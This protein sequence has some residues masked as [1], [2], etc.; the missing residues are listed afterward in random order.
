MAAE[1]E[2]MEMVVRLVGENERYLHS[3][4]EA[5]E[6]TESAAKH[7]EAAT[8]HVKHFSEQVEGFGRSAANALA[9]L[10]LATSAEQA[11]E[12][13][14]SLE[15]TTLRLEAAIEGNGR[16]A[17]RAM[18]QYNEFAAAMARTTLA[19]R[20]QALS[21]VQT[22]EMMG[23][24]GEHAERAAR[25]AYFL[26]TAT[27]Q[28]AESMIYATTAME[29]GNY[30][31][32]RRLPGLRGVHDQTM[33][34]DR[35]QRMI[36]QGQRMENNLLE[37]TGGQL[38]KLKRS[39]FELTVQIGKL[40]SEGLRPIID[41]T[42]RAID[43]F[44]TLSPEV[45]RVAT[46]V[47]AFAL[48]LLSL[49]AVSFIIAP[50]VSGFK[51]LVLLVSAVFSPI[52][53]A[54]AVVVGILALLVDELGGVSAVYEML[55]A[56]A[57]AAWDYIKQKALDAWDATKRGV[58]IVWSYVKPVVNLIR[59]AFHGLYTWISEHGAEV[60]DSAVAGVSEFG[61][62]AYDY[63][64]TAATAAAD[65]AYAARGAALATGLLAAAF[66]AGYVVYYSASLAI[67]LIA[68][69]VSFLHLEALLGVAAWAL[70]TGAVLVAK[71]VMLAFTA[72]VAAYSAVTAIASGVSAAYAGVVWL[73]NA[74]IAAYNF[75]SAA[76]SVATGTWGIALLAAGAAM[77]VAKAATWLLNA[78][79]TVMHFLLDGGIV[80][81][82]AFAA[83]VLV[84][85]GVLT[86]VGS[87][88]TILAAGLVA[89]FAAPIVFVR[90]LVA[91]CT[92]LIDSL[93]N[94]GTA[95]QGMDAMTSTFGEWWEM[96]KDI[97]AVASE[98]VPAAW[99][100][101]K[102]A[103][104]VMVSQMKDMWQPTW[105]FLKDI[106]F[107]VWDAIKAKLTTSI[108]EG[109]LTAAQAVPGMQQ[110]LGFS[111][112]DMRDMRRS[113]TQTNQL[114]DR[115]LRDRV[116]AA[117]QN[118]RVEMS[119]ETREA[120]DAYDELMDDVTDRLNRRENPLTQ[121]R[122]QWEHTGH[123]LGREMMSGIEK[124]L[125]KFDATE[126]GSSEFFTRLQEYT[127]KI[128]SEGEGHLGEHS[129]EGSGWWSWL[130]QEAHAAP[131]A[132]GNAAAENDR[133][134]N[135]T[136]TLLQAIANN[137]AVIAGR[138]PVVLP[139]AGING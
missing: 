129:R 119:D 66:A 54:V 17:E 52:G 88:A 107:A 87:L 45:K 41:Y 61:S 68:G 83:A 71:F 35:A 123:D 78:A 2:L 24:T 49:E 16:A 135:N 40:I 30:H 127:E 12:K 128:K 106:V 90:E 81:V 114:I 53:A 99:E 74:A 97:V 72:A 96:L 132:H 3:L 113:L 13:F 46:Y 10:G 110:L 124:E 76:A 26:A 85:A 109:V 15:R 80:V 100:V 84:F 122:N 70:W 86:G 103:F 121:Q 77:L 95:S 25:N 116:T 120:R 98:D 82:L 33:L 51:L 91:T 118:F 115:N 138:P 11:F 18:E 55:S 69:A 59:V 134:R 101:A 22:A 37:S 39:F 38:T 75:I 108:I 23:V 47:L 28:S 130:P 20:P 8:E 64:S 125:H 62:T 48:A 27:N 111:D 1:E 65:L 4:D 7:I 131:A 29:Q 89:L 112:D 117:R 19:T 9:F 56:N 136:Q 31:L 58:A 36:A 73:V 57:G 137:T 93:T 92:E 50:I 67:G 34:L 79:L 43:W 139:P 44:N 42:K 63:L 126:F 105:N 5:V 104:A 6:H 133:W 94:V 21:L 102:A 60:W 14:E 32:L